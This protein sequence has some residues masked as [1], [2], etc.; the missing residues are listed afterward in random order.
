M[1]T[2]DPK[3]V[4]EE[5]PKMLVEKDK[6]V[7]YPPGHAKQGRAVI[8]ENEGEEKAYRNVGGKRKDKD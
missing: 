6:P 3:W 4:P 8:F 2:T 5:Y 1:K 7:I